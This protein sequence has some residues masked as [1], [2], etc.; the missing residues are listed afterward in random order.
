MKPIIEVTPAGMKN[1]A[2][3]VEVWPYM[4]GQFRIQLLND[5]SLDILRECCTYESARCREVLVGLAQADDPPAYLETLA[6]PHNCEGKGGRIRLDTTEA[7]NP[8]RQHQGGGK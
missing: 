2:Y 1:P 4:F 8:H 3:R 5:A 7:D 6:T